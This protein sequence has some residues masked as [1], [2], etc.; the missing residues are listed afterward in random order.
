MRS[1][2]SCRLLLLW[3]PTCPTCPTYFETPWEKGEG[4]PTRAREKGWTGWTGWTNPD[5][6]F[7]CGCPTSPFEVGHSARRLDRASVRH[8]LAAG[9]RI[10]DPAARPA[11]N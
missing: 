1:R 3:C 10:P 6:C 9:R 4:P 11:L 7:L 8:L 5:Y 2:S